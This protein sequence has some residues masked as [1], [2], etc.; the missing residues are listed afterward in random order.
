MF[1]GRIARNVRLRQTGLAR[2]EA[3]CTNFCQQGAWP[4]ADRRRVH[5]VRRNAKRVRPRRTCE[6]TPNVRGHAERGGM[7][8]WPHLVPP[9]ADWNA[10]DVPPEAIHALGVGPSIVRARAYFMLGE[11]LLRRTKAVEQDAAIYSYVMAHVLRPDAAAYINLGVVLRQSG[12]IAAARSAF[13]QAVAHT[14]GVSAAFTNLAL[15]PGTAPEEAAAL[16]QRAVSLAPSDGISYASLAGALKRRGDQEGARAAHALSLRLS[17]ASGTV[18]FGDWRAWWLAFYER[19]QQQRRPT[20]DAQWP[21]TEAQ[22]IQ[23]QAS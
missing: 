14:P 21:R 5:R 6:A 15:L 20:D 16:L 13:N 7:D 3:A 12:R 9:P 8:G 2:K 4:L 18:N 22:G 23:Y 19:R 17:P 11:S 10:I 1:K